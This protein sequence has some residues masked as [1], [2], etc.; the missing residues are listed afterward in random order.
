M[1]HVRSSRCPHSSPSLAQGTAGL[2]AELKVGHMG[3][4]AMGRAWRS[5][6][7]TWPSSTAGRSLGFS[8]II[9]IPQL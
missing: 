3:M 2:I 1:T 6:V 7:L 8:H 5:W 4:L 9:P